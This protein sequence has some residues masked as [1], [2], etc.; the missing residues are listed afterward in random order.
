MRTRFRVTYIGFSFERNPG[1]SQDL[2][3]TSSQ[4]GLLGRGSCLGSNGGTS[5]VRHF[6][7]C[8]GDDEIEKQC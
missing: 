3:F 2:D 8:V 4:L 7:S 1:S 6:G 5:L